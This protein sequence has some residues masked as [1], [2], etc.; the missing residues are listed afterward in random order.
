MHA[1]A[2]QSGFNDHFVGALHGA[3]A[4]GKA[5]SLKGGVLHMGFAF[6]QISEVL[7]NQGQGGLRWLQALQFG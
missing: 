2:F 6:L 3:R 7:R 4:N 5:L 1:S